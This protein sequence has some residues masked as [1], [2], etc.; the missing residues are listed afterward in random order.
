MAACIM[1]HCPLAFLFLS[2]R[3]G[4]RGQRQLCCGMKGN[5]QL[6]NALC[7][8]SCRA[9]IVQ[10]LCS[11]VVPLR[12]QWVGSACMQSHDATGRDFLLCRCEAICC[13]Q[14][15]CPV[16]LHW[17]VISLR[18]GNC[19]VQ[20][21]DPWAAD[22]LGGRTALHYAGRSDQAE[23]CSL[24]IEAAAHTMACPPPPMRFPNKSTTK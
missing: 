13:M 15:W 2:V 19:L 8:C 3:P 12:P 20:G 24:L 21:A 23:I 7:C 1:K 22:R 18:C 5:N 11:T 16:Q 9:K 6:I 10:I 14:H 17:F 4:A